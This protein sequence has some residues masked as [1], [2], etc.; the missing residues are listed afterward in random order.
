MTKKG[1]YFKTFCRII[2]A[3]GT[4]RNRDGLL[5]LIVQ[6]V[7]DTMDGKAACL[8]LT[9]PE[10]REFLA[11]AQK[12]LSKKYFRTTLRSQK[13]IPI[14]SKEGYLHARD[15]LSDPRLEDHEGKKAEGIASMLI[16]P[17]KVMNQVIGVLSLYTGKQRDFTGDEIEFLTALAEQ[18]GIAIEQSRLMDQLRKYTRLFHDLS[19]SINSSLELRTIFQTLTEETAKALGVKASSILL[20]NKE[21][22]T[23]ELVTSYGLS[24]QYLSRGPLSVEKSMAET[25]SGKPVMIENAVAD[26]RVQHQEEKKKEGIASILSVPVMAKNEVIGALRLYS[27]TRRKFTDDEIMF[28][29]ALAHQGGLAIMN[30]SCFVALEK[31]MKELKE[32]IWSHRSWF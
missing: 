27:A 22:K 15:A 8:W 5:D 6:S 30:A 20:I 24:S 31:D 9:D 11:V 32:D 16:V 10:T 25:L 29:T 3:F 14:I 19:V 7:I 17:V 23:L 28:T 18:G 1:D 21:K 26:K 4:I 2:N 13:I 12:G